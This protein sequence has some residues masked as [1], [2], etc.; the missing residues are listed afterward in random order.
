MK[1]KYSDSIKE[2]AYK[3][4]QTGLGR[5]KISQ[6]LGIPASTVR[7]WINSFKNGKNI[8]KD[9]NEDFNE[10]EDL[11]IQLLNTDWR[12]I[13][14]QAIQYADLQKET[15][16]YQN[17]FEIDL[18][19]YDKKYFGIIFSSDWH[20]GSAWTDY[21][22]FMKMIDFI[23]ENKIKISIVGD[24]IDN[25]ILKHL[26]YPMLNST[27]TPRLQKLMLLNLLNELVKND[28][29]LNFC[30]GNHELFD[31]RLVGASILT[32]FN[33]KV[34]ISHNRAVFYLK[35]KNIKYKIVEVH[36]ALGS[37][38]Y[39]KTHAAQRE[40]RWHHPDA[41][42]IVTAHR[43]FPCVVLDYN[44]RKFQWLVRLGTFKITDEYTYDYWDKS[45]TILNPIF[46][47]N[48]KIHEIIW[49]QKLEHYKHFKE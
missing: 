36:K 7:N 46:L 9:K 37:S 34:P 22:E 44:F 16:G 28:C 12:K 40:L 1:N 3:L 4:W 38:I 25:F 30:L 15:S 6:I 47:F 11:N 35:F 42:V 19:N 8:I 17:E 41:D 26:K 48:T 23:L 21:K 33:L 49:L 27:L 10:N 29:L 43:H 2:E 45:A 14:N 24:T 32:Y 20:L 18:T 13:I 5:I 39:N 31:E